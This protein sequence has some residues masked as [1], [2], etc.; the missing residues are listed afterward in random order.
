M[1]IPQFQHGAVPRAEQESTTV[2][3]AGARAK[4]YGP[5]QQL[6][7][8]V[9]EFGNKVAQAE[10]EAEYQRLENGLR[11]ESADLWNG[12]QE[13]DQFD[14]N[15]APTYDTLKA[16]FNAGYKKLSEKYTSQIKHHQ[17]KRGFGDSATD[18]QFAYGQDVDR[19]TRSRQVDYLNG[20]YSR[21]LNDLDLDDP[22]AQLKADD[23]L[24]SA[25]AGG[26]W[27]PAQAESQRLSFRSRKSDHDLTNDFN[28]ARDPS[29]PHATL[30]FVNSYEFPEWMDAG[31]ADNYRVSWGA[32]ANS[33]QSKLNS[34]RN[35]RKASYK[36]ANTDIN[37]A[38]KGITTVVESGATLSDEFLDQA[39]QIIKQ[40]GEL[41]A[42]ASNDGVALDRDSISD[43]QNALR[44]HFEGQVI[45]Q[46]EGASY[47]NLVAQKQLLDATP[48]E[49]TEDGLRSAA[50]SKMLGNVITQI[51][52]DPDA[53][54]V[55]QGLLK[56]RSITLSGAIE[57][58]N[59]TDFLRESKGRT[60]IVNAHWGLS[61][62]LLTD[63]ETSVLSKH[64]D[65]PQG[66]PMLGNVVDTLGPESD[67]FLAN[68]MG[69]GKPVLAVT[70]DLYR[71]ADATS[72]INALLEAK[73]MEEQGIISE[74]IIKDKSAFYDAVVDGL[75]DDGSE[76][77]P[78]E[79]DYT[80]INAISKTINR[81]YGALAADAGERDT[82]IINEDL[83][84][85]AFGMV[86]GGFVEVNGA[87]VLSARRDMTDDDME[88]WVKSISAK[89]LLDVDHDLKDLDT[90]AD[91]VHTGKVKL[92]TTGEQG[93]YQLHRSGFVVHHK[94][95]TTA[96]PIAFELRYK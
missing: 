5:A 57:S 76:S 79:G 71:Q 17:N 81:V 87:R 69:K 27:T 43:M 30:D 50:I 44:Y 70:G 40:S 90:L 83:F 28:A 15:G 64:L 1:R 39:E 46:G 67:D 37:D 52:S 59:I 12:L 21:N 35:E 14:E 45:I 7:K 82:D 86:V 22:N 20:Q 58:G 78:Y 47:D 9:T 11:Q 92:V 60:S 75:T 16:D 10:A 63:E 23:I 56:P 38:A 19:V 93:V 55:N 2:I 31:K 4:M 29:N 25:M 54:A 85:K 95:S 36:A 96:N 88:V 6:T 84:S 3:A 68:I 26:V 74:Y 72:A 48:V 33:D 66:I 13:R 73:R 62:K 42:I 8:V 51:E 34:A 32:K 49:S 18:I 65:T 61:T 24:E 77:N 94:D 41:N 89:D 53:A 91:E 80:Y